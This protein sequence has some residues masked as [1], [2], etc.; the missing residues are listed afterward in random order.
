ML[1]NEIMLRGIYVVVL[2]Y[3]VLSS[4]EPPWYANN[5]TI[6]QESCLVT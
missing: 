6:S 3:E 2:S 4:S 1:L 5:E